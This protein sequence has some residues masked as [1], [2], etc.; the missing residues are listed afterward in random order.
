MNKCQQE[1]CFQQGCRF[2]TFNV[3]W[4]DNDMAKSCKFSPIYEEE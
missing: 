1:E 3:S 2:D 4:C